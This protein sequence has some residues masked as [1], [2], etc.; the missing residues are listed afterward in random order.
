VE[1][2]DEDNGHAGKRFRLTIPTEL[3]KCYAASRFNKSIEMI[4]KTPEVENLVTITFGV[5]K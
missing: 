3:L 2:C 1:W 4:S 5:D